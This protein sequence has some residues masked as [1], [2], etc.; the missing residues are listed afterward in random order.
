MTDYPDARSLLPPLSFAAAAND[1]HH[2]GMSLYLNAVVQKQLVLVVEDVGGVY[3]IAALDTE[4]GAG[5]VH[6]QGAAGEEELVMI[7]GGRDVWHIDE[8]KQGLSKRPMQM[9]AGAVVEIPE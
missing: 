4:H 6:I 5:L 1:T 2:I 9:L 3:P 8:L 7:A